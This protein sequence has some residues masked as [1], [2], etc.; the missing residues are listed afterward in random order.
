MRVGSGKR[1]RSP[2]AWIMAAAVVVTVVLA[3]CTPAAH[4]TS[5]GAVPSPGGSV[6]SLTNIS[7]LKS[8][9]NR[10]DGRPRLVLIF[11]PT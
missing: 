10:D 1:L 2:R 8:L 7:T 9:F 4:P 11:S 5:P 6:V 3:S